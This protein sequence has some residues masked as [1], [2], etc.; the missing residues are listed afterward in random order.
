MAASVSVQSAASPEVD[1]FQTLLYGADP[2]PGVVAVE[3]AGETAIL[4]RREAGALRREERPFRPWLLATEIA[5]LAD[6][7][8][9]E[10]DGPGCRFRARFRHWEAFQAGRETLRERGRRVVSPGSAARR[11][12][13][14]SGVTLF[15]GMGFDDLHRMQI[16][17]ETVDLD[18]AAPAHRILLAAACDNQGGEWLLQDEDEGRLI[19]ALA[20]LIRQ[21]DPDT[22]EG[23]NLFAFDLPFLMARASRAGVSLALGR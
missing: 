15:G 6:A 17:L 22:L 19:A 16:D 23:H 9:E 18:P 4:L 12:L 1:E 3:A 14:D 5:A 2:T 13:I 21:R 7:E 20:E 11:F 8:W 10:L